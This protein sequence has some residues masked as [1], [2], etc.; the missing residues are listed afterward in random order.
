[1]TLAPGQ[2]GQAN[3]PASLSR[4]YDSFSLLQR[5][6]WHNTVTG[7][8]WTITINFVILKKINLLFSVS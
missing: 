8:V 5:R 2:A 4:V 7:F 6:L 3:K 1:M